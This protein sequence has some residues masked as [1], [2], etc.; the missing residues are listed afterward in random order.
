MLITRGHSSGICICEY[1]VLPLEDALP[2]TLTPWESLSNLYS[3]HSNFLPLVLMS[4]IPICQ[5]TDTRISVVWVKKKKIHPHKATLSF[6][7][8]RF[9]SVTLAWTISFGFLRV[10]ILPQVIESASVLLS[11]AGRL[12]RGVSNRGEKLAL[13]WLTCFPNTTMNSQLQGSGR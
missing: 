7:G 8:V 5:K 12:A 4:G 11:L 6:P 2:P 1:P 10:G 9:A 13:L 3:N